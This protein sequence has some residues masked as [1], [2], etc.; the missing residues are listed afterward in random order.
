[1]VPG[2]LADLTILDRDIYAIDPHE[3]RSVKPA[4]TVVGGRFVH[5]T[6]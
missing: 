5:D 6:L 1:M 3:I 4:A 2:K